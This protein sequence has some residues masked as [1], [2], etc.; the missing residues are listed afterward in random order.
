MPRT[1]YRL[2]DRERRRD[3]LGPALRDEFDR[4]CSLDEDSLPEPSVSGRCTARLGMSSSA[5]STETMNPPGLGER[6]FTYLV[7]LDG[8]RTWATI[9]TC[10]TWP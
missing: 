2:I 4:L 9:A 5:G 6:P 3:L 1:R 8:R 10:G 7:S